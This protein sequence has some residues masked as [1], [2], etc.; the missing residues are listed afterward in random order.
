MKG[1]V[2][3]GSARSSGRFPADWASHAATTSDIGDLPAPHQT[4]RS[5]L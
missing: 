1:N 2:T 3:S 5:N 4:A